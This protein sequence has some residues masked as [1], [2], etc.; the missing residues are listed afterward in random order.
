MASLERLRQGGCY[1]LE[2]SLDMGCMV[3]SRPAWHAVKTLHPGTFHSE[4]YR[5][6]LGLQTFF[7]TLPSLMLI[8]GRMIY[9]QYSRRE[10]F[11]CACLCM[12]GM[13]A[14]VCASVSMC[15]LRP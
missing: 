6:C 10:R 3:A 2:V 12:Y 15:L 9:S 1:K 11:W 4:M 13:C 7:V 8:P 14:D 5:L